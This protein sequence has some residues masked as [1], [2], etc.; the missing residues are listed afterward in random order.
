MGKLNY[1]G[2][3]VGDIIWVAS[4]EEGY[5]ADIFIREA[6]PKKRKVKKVHIEMSESDFGIY[7][8]RSFITYG[9]YFT[10]NRL[11]VKRLEKY[12][13]KTKAD[14]QKLC[15]IHNCGLPEAARHSQ[16]QRR[17]NS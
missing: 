8:V 2:Y 4:S 14:C 12:V 11:D 9:E 7:D 1:M 16:R 15:D 10:E 6:F 3:E 13:A 5:L 17:V